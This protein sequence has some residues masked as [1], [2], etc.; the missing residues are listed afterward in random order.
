MASTEQRT[1]PAKTIEIFV[2]NKPVMIEDRNVTG[3]EIKDAADID[4][5]FKLYDRK[6]KEI[7]NDETVRV[8]P[9]EK[10]TAIS[11]QDVS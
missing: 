5:S 1:K 11:G 8:H 6:G 10:F 2:N 9:T 3:A 4:L 7:A